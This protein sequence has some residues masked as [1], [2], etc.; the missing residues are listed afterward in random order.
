MLMGKAGGESRWTSMWACGNRG[1]VL[2]LSFVTLSA[3]QLHNCSGSLPSHGSMPLHS[4]VI[5]IQ[6][7]GDRLRL[8]DGS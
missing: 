2:I 3:A 6:R 8:A 1:N 4:I 5:P 7:C